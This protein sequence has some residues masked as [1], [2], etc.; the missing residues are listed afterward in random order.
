MQDPFSFLLRGLGS[1]ITQ[2]GDKH[3]IMESLELEG[4]SLHTHLGPWLQLIHHLLKQIQCSH[5]LHVWLQCQGV[6]QALFVQKM[7]SN[8]PFIWLR[9][10]WKIYNPNAMK[11]PEGGIETMALTK[12]FLR[13]II[14]LGVT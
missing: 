1:I 2:H 14:G 5:H 9:L 8:E 7:L 4:T 3:R 10:Q 11:A 6:W 12:I 13:S